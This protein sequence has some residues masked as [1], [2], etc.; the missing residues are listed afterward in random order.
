[1]LIPGSDD[2][3]V[4]VENAKCKGMQ[5]FTVIHATHAGIMRNRTAIKKTI[6]FLKHGA[7]TDVT[8]K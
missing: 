3:K 6:K 8:A 1:M 5:D 2:G 4:S 7:F